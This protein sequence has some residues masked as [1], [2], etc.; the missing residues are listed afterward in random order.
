MKKRIHFL[1]CLL[2]F[3]IAGMGQNMSV[4]KDGAAPDPSAMLDVSDTA[5]G[6]LVPRMT[7][8]QRN[9]IT[10]PATGLLIFQTNSDS[11]FYFNQ[12]TPSV[13]VWLRIQTSND[14]IH[15]QKQD[16]NLFYTI[17]NIGVG[18]ATP[19]SVMHLYGKGS[20]GA[21]A[22]I[23]FGDDYRSTTNQWNSFVGESGW[24]SNTDS[25]QLQIHGRQGQFF[26]VG[27][28][29][30]TLD[31]AMM[32][33]SGGA[34][35]IGDSVLGG[36]LNIASSG[37]NFLRMHTDSGQTGL[38]V[39]NDS[40]E[41][42][43]FSDSKGGSLLPQG[44]LGLF[45]PSSGIAWSINKEGNMGV[46]DSDASH[47]LQVGNYTTNE[48]Q[49]L[50]IKTGG[51]NLWKSG[52][53]F[54]HFSD[55]LGFSL[56]SDETVNRF[57]IQRHNADTTTALSIDRGSGYI[58]LATESPAV[59]LAIGPSDDDT[60]FETVADGNLA[61]YTNGTERVRFDENGYVGIGTNDPSH[62]FHASTS[63]V[64]AGAFES[65]NTQATW[66]RL[67]NSGGG[68]YHTLISTGS[69]SS[70]GA[71][72]LLFGY[73]TTSN[74]SSVAMTISDNL[75][76][77]GTTSP[78]LTLSIGPT[79]DDTGFENAADG[80]LALY[81]NG[82]ERVR[83]DENGN[84]GIGVTN[85]NRTLHAHAASAAFGQFTTSSTGSSI[86]D[87]MV[88][89]YA[90]AV[91]AAIFNYENTN[92]AFGTN[93]AY[94][95]Y[96][97]P[98]GK[99]GIG[100]SSPEGALSLNSGSVAGVPG[101][102]FDGFG[103]SEGEIAV[104]N[105]ETLNI[106]EWD[107]STFTENMRIASNGRVAIGTT[108]ANSL[109]TLG[110]SAG[111][112]AGGV[113][114]QNGTQDWFIY[115]NSSNDLVFTDEST[116]IVTFEGDGDVGIKTTD[117]ETDF[118]LNHTSGVS[119]GLS[120]SNASGGTDRWQFYVFTTDDMVLR[121]NSTTIGTFDHST[122]TYTASS[123]LNR[124]KNIED[125]GTILSKIDN[126]ELKRYNFK[127]EEDTDNKHYGFIA[128]ELMKEFPSLVKLNTGDGETDNYTVD[129]MT[130]AA[131]A[132]GA[133]KEQ[134][135]TI[136]ELKKKLDELERKL[137]NK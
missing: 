14:S 120:I 105:G 111:T 135:A 1:V 52:I 124:K 122:G 33:N 13:P 117:P 23:V 94:R 134:Q 71:G 91:G 12:G 114:F 51:G 40:A 69:A 8:A 96:L 11:G 50:S 85:P 16:T 133:I 86:S 38:W 26:T 107:G 35:T 56:F 62:F 70:I 76:G 83:F 126:L 34:V 106:G 21:G 3:S 27:S 125:A 19:Q 97:D 53:I 31:T 115:Q 137:N 110:S 46:G 20:L 36:R 42:A 132:L 24:D 18:T 127:T 74:T 72:K 79:D 22:R 113:N 41:W 87:G 2:L 104:D 49:F 54:K 92:L 108:T 75:I 9:L 65:S 57:Y 73:G 39:S 68:K 99:L 90:D 116:D 45:T 82:V 43:I 123:D 98:D 25:D 102:F 101:V 78:A 95:M 10:N 61:L 7:M 4:N 109:L 84:V 6:V 77:I 60:G 66:L 81:T 44:G 29:A 112:T 80:N 28:P 93:N 5:S 129:Y 15:W 32:I 58:G 55:D 47:A 48:D 88:L 63:D 64:I 100:V 17:G 131:V 89:G 30:A 128:Q 103:A 136:K 119:N 121:F 130:M 59:Q 118:H 37:S 67:R